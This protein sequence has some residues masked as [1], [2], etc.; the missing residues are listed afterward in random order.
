[1]FTGYCPVV[2][3]SLL[4]FINPLESNN[5]YKFKLWPVRER[6]HTRKHTHTGFTCHKV[7]GP[8]KMM[9]NVDATEQ[10]TRVTRSRTAFISMQKVFKIYRYG[11]SKA[12][13]K[14]V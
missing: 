3:P 4:L 2:N 6:V 8:K 12:Q 13:V 5:N 11:R 9:W 7:A 1:M 14:Q 10:N